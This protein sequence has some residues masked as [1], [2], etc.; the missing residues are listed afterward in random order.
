MLKITNLISKLPLIKNLLKLPCG[1]YLSA[2]NGQYHG[3]K[4]S[5]MFDLVS[6]CNV[7]GLKNKFIYNMQR[8]DKA[9]GFLS[10]KR[11]SNGTFAEAIT[12]NGARWAD[13]YM[14]AGNEN[15]I[16]HFMT[17]NEV[18][19][20]KVDKSSQLRGKNP[21]E[22]EWEIL[23]FATFSLLTPSNFL[24]IGFPKTD[25]NALWDAI[26]QTDLLITS[27]IPTQ[28]AVAEFYATNI[29]SNGQTSILLCYRP[30]QTL[31]FVASKGKILTVKTN[32]FRQLSTAVTDFQMD[33]QQIFA[34]H[35]LDEGCPF[36]VWGATSEHMKSGFDLCSRVTE[37]KD[38]K[39]LTDIEHPE[40]KILETNF[41]RKMFIPKEITL[42]QEKRTN[43]QYKR[44]FW[45][46][47]SAFLLIL[48]VF[49]YFLPG[50]I[51]GS[52]SGTKS[53]LKMLVPDPKVEIKTNS[54][55]PDDTNYTFEPLPDVKPKEMFSPIKIDKTAADYMKNAVDTTLFPD[56]AQ[57]ITSVINKFN[58]IQPSERIEKRIILKKQVSA[59]LVLY[60][61]NIRLKEINDFLSHEQ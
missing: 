20:F 36:Y 32:N 48:C 37:T 55:T 41:T 31:V 33:V 44:T 21:D 3:E 29:A 51:M 61:D 46:V 13:G 11:T 45:S 60:P 14:I 35:K 26:S 16:L 12:Q 50:I 56:E 57:I 30:N 7:R 58:S 59:L 28:L 52:I 24:A 15:V 5:M 53:L 4:I 42:K 25:Y 23:D 18:A 27:L 22:Y 38:V 54:I 10:G 49:V 1:Y 8:F 40:N 2:F 34:Q 17:P 19:E 9:P 47:I 43:P 39:Y 6:T